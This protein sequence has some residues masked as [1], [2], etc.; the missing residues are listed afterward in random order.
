[1]SSAQQRR[2]FGTSSPCG[3]ARPQVCCGSLS[4]RGH[5]ARIVS[6]YLTCGRRE[7]LGRDIS[8]GF[9]AELEQ[10]ENIDVCGERGEYHSFSFGGPM[11]RM[12]LELRN[13][14]QF[15]MENHLI[16]DINVTAEGL[17]AR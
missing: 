15:E 5:Q 4:I 7:W 8:E 1:M 9:V 3:V 10:T 6:V 13:L 12:P 2:I 16:L 17:L 11:F 14:S